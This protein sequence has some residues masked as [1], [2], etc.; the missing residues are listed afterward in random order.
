MSGQEEIVIDIA[1]Y[2]EEGKL[3][4]LEGDALTKYILQSIDRHERR[5][6]EAVEKEK[7]GRES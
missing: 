1:T 5:L 4:G 3:I 7:A 2:K 6:A